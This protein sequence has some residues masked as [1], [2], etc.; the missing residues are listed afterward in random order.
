MNDNTLAVEDL[1]R[2]FDDAHAA[3]RGTTPGFRDIGRRWIA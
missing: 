3:D 1:D 2:R